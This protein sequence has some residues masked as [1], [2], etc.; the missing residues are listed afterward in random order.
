VNES[1]RGA[2]T[3]VDAIGAELIDRFDRRLRL[4]RAGSEFLRGARE[5]IA[6]SERTLQDARRA[7]GCETQALSVAFAPSILNSV[8]VTSILRR[9]E[10]RNPA[11]RLEVHAAVFGHS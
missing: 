3:T 11:A 9:F 8:R 7:A 5:V 6:T 10:E 4:T 2:K 1:R